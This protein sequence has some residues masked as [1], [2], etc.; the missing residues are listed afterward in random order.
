MIDTPLPPPSSGLGQALSASPLRIRRLP[1]GRL[2]GRKRHGEVD[3]SEFEERR[4]K[5][6]DASS[7][8]LDEVSE[9]RESEDSREGRYDCSSNV[10]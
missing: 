6:D 3:E 10:E 4:S 5:S 2:G 1:L 8:K 7:R 9:G